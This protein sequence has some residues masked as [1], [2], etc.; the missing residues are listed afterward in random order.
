MN[1]TIIQN[2]IY[3]IREQKAM[4][5]FDLAE[6]YDVETKVLNQA[7]KRNRDRF[8]VDFM[9]RLTKKE[10]ESLRSQIVTLKNGRGKYPKYLPYVFTEHGVTMLASIL[11]SERAVK[12]NIAIVRAFIALRQIALYHKDLAE[13][14]DQLKNEMYDRLGEHDTQLNAIYDAI[15]NMLDDKSEKKNWEQRERIGFKK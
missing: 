9:F 14:L 12:M 4:L 10:W 5:D 15:E 1:L 13:K 11:R 2:K 6:L 8:P 7:V 3:E